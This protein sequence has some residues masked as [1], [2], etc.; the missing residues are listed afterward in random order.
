[1]R[2]GQEWEG[3]GKQ[4]SRREVD[5]AFPSEL[6]AFLY[7]PAI[8]TRH[9]FTVA[10]FGPRTCMDDTRDDGEGSSHYID[11]RTLMGQGS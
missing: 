11:E 8:H 10:M 4:Y 2:R 1:M 9:C 3:K 7:N 5:K 6:E